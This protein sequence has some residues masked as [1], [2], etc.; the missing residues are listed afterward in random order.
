MMKKP[1]RVDDQSDDDEYTIGPRPIRTDYDDKD[2]ILK[3]L[4]LFDIKEIYKKIFKKIVVMDSSV[5]E[6]YNWI[7]L[8][9]RQGYDVMSKHSDGVQYCRFFLEEIC[10]AIDSKCGE[11][12]AAKVLVHL[13]SDEFLFHD[14]N[15][16]Y[17][18][19]HKLKVFCLLDPKEIHG[20]LQ[21]YY[22]FLTAIINWL[23]KLAISS[24]IDFTKPNPKDKDRNPQYDL[25][26]EHHLLWKNFSSKVETTYNLL[27]NRSKRLAMYRDL[28]IIYHKNQTKEDLQKTT[29]M[30]TPNHILPLL[31]KNLNMMTG[32]VFDRTI[33]DYIPESRLV[34]HKYKPEL[35][36]GF[37]PQWVGD[38]LQN[39]Q[40]L[41][42]KLMRTI[43][44]SLTGNTKNK[45]ATF[46]IGESDVGKTTFFSG[47]RY[48]LRTNKNAG[49]IIALCQNTVFQKVRRTAGGP[50]SDIAQLKGLLIALFEELDRKLWDN[51]SFKRIVGGKDI[52]CGARDLFQSNRS[53]ESVL[54]A[55]CFLLFNPCSVPT[56]PSDNAVRKRIDVIKF[57]TA[58]YRNQSEYD[59]IPE[60]RRVYARK[61]DSDVEENFKSKRAASQFFN[62]LLT[63]VTINHQ[64]GGPPKRNKEDMKLVDKL[65]E[66]GDVITP[67]FEE[68]L[69][70]SPLDNKN[71]NP[72]TTQNTI[73]LTNL[74]RTW[75]ESRRDAIRI[76]PSAKQFKLMIEEV[77][78]KK[79]KNSI[80][81]RIKPRGGKTS[82]QLHLVGY[83]YIEE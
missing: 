20:G 14:T 25:L 54:S 9:Y 22:D 12:T 45:T 72:Y 19:N 36:F 53:A 78:N 7:K 1:I 61:L 51:E 2:D 31:N 21:F 83:K 55:H 74:Y 77:T 37:F 48:Y 33:E 40:R 32:E 73:P 16:C 62:Y 49:R 67:F 17:I 23:R 44:Y 10:A 38:L 58:W 71:S 8:S 64:L 39:D 80:I 82:I 30:Q 34:Y 4:D 18:F 24:A 59:Q 69:I 29:A 13:M 27:Q 50:Q 3:F 68:Y 56:I 63:F 6:P 11:Y 43:A 15:T 47:L 41:V 70:E 46:I 26:L 35:G 65:F 60:E 81:K 75:L 66:T 52:E 79:G 5:R 42:E 28:K 76:C 57:R